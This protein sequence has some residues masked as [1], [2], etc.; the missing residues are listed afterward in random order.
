VKQLLRSKRLAVGLMAL[1]VFALSAVP[2]LA[3]GPT[4]PTIDVASYG[5]AL[6]TGL[7]TAVSAI[8]PYAGVITAFAIGVGMV[9]RWLG[10]RK[11]TG[12]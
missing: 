11:A 1:A 4:A 3:L 6:L 9:K 10:H 12:V 5:D 2:A 7:G 8:F